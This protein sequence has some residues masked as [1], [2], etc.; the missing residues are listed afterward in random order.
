MKIEFVIVTHN[1]LFYFFQLTFFYSQF[2][3]STLNWLGIGFSALF[4][5]D[6]IRDSCDVNNKCWYWVNAW[7]NKIKFN[8][9]NANQLNL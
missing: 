4:C 3:S 8:F 9:I 1:I 2:N 5:L 7:F 6:F